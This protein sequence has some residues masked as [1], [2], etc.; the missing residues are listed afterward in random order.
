M[1]S[2]ILVNKPGDN[3]QYYHIIH[4]DMLTRIQ[5]DRITKALLSALAFFNP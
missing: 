4:Y 5:N 3:I 1:H 2:K